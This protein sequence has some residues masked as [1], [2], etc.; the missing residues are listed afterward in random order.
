MQRSPVLPY[1]PACTRRGGIWG[2]IT[3]SVAPSS[4]CIPGGQGRFGVNQSMGVY[5]D[6]AFRQRRFAIVHTPGNVLM[7]NVD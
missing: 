2:S 3:R 4:K 5:D 1:S 6:V 7:G